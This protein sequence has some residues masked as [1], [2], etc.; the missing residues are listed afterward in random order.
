[1]SGLQVLSC[2]RIQWSMHKV[3]VILL[4]ASHDELDIV[5]AA[6]LGATSYMI[7]P[8]DVNDLLARLDQALAARSR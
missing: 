7:K 8:F 3:P 1:M 4:T 2:L 5:R 6:E